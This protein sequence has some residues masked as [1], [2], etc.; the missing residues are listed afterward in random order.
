MHPL[1]R[2]VHEIFQLNERLVTNCLDGMDDETAQKRFAPST[3]NAAFLA[4]HLVDA[5]HYVLGLLGVESEHPFGSE[6]DEARGVDDVERFPTVAELRDAWQTVA[7]KL[8]SA[9][10]EAAEEQLTA[11]APVGFPVADKSLAGGL[12]FLAQHE[13]YHVGQLALLRKA[14]G[15][16]AMSYG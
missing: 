6:Y 5:R 1:V 2:P 4:L 9:L 14:H 12:A 13:S 8:A 3:N 16:G 15:L 11:D 7:G 10:E